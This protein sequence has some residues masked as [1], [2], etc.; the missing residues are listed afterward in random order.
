MRSNAVGLT[1]RITAEFLLGK[2]R[3]SS[4]QGEP[5][6]LM[7]LRALCLQLKKSLG[8]EAYEGFSEDLKPVFHALAD[9]IFD[10][11]TDTKRE[12]TVE[13]LKA[14]PVPQR[15]SVEV[16]VNRLTGKSQDNHRWEP[17]LY[18]LRMMLIQ[19]E[20]LSISG[21]SLDEIRE[22]YHDLVHGVIDELW[23]HRATLVT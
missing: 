18:R 5:E 19:M 8:D 9:T 2:I 22:G 21:L 12:A 13:A 6:Y 15:A 1:A 7:T 3:I 20:E 14:L 23:N 10:A 16:L 11:L 4:R 17:G